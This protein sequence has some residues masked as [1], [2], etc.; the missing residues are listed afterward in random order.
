MGCSC[1]A[2]SGSASGG[3][4]GGGNLSA[5]NGRER[6]RFHKR[7]EL[8]LASFAP[9]L[10]VSPEAD[11]ACPGGDAANASALVPVTHKGG[12]AG[13]ESP[14]VLLESPQSPMLA[15]DPAATATAL[16]PTGTT[17]G[18]GAFVACIGSSAGF[19]MTSTTDAP[20]AAS[21]APSM[22]LLGASSPLAASAGGDRQHQANG[23]AQLA[24]STKNSRRS[25]RQQRHP[26]NNEAALLFRNH[27]HVMSRRSSS[28]CAAGVGGATTP[29]GGFSPTSSPAM[30]HRAFPSGRGGGSM[31]GGGSVRGAVTFPDATDDVDMGPIQPGRLTLGIASHA[32]ASALNIN[33]AQHHPL[34]GGRHGSAAA[35]PSGTPPRTPQ[36]G[37]L[38]PGGDRDAAGRQVPLQL[39][40]VESYIDTCVLPNVVLFED[41][42]AA[43]A[44]GATGNNSLSYVQP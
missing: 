19:E 8:A 26:Q 38:R 32:V 12:G 4:G 39:G 33:H 35:S 25:M 1:S 34:G 42:A 21:R 27:P 37:S 13:D 10:L 24:L 29:G 15:T 5:M 16:T 2:A 43:A 22:T 11:E 23:A 40:A 44:D 6:Q 14:H 7:A 28:A 41:S 36:R 30:V 17:A 9:I 18:S 20:T 3:R 31:R